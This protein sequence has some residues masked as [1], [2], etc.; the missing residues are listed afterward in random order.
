MK[1]PDEIINPGEEQ[2]KLQLDCVR[3]TIADDLK[4]VN[5]GDTNGLKI[6][7]LDDK[8]YKRI[9]DLLKPVP[10]LPVKVSKQPKEE[11]LE[12]DDTPK[13]KLNI[14]DFALKKI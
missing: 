6:L 10:E 13:K 8:L 14:Q 7:S 9:S 12:D 11:V 4:I 1:K 5:S 3:Q 2:L